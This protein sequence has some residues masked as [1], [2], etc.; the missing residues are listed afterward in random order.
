MLRPVDLAHGAPD[1]PDALRRAERL[2]EAAHD[3]GLDLTGLTEPGGRVAA[4]ACQLAP[5]LAAL[6]A[7]DPYLNRLV[8]RRLGHPDEEAFAF[9]LAAHTTAVSQLFA[10]LGE[11]AA[12]PADVIA[13]LSGEL[14]EDAE[15]EALARLGFVDLTMAGAEL[16]RARRHPGSPL[17][18][19]ASDRIARVGAALLTEIASS[20]DPDQALRFLGELCARRPGEW[21]IWRLLDE[22]PAICCL[23]GSVLG[24]SAYLARTLIDTPELIDLLVDVGIT[25]PTRT[26]AQLANDLTAR[27]ATVEPLD[28]EATWS[29]L[30]EVKN[31]HVLRVGLADV[32]GAL[33]PLAVCA[34]LTA[35]A[36]A[37]VAQALAIITAQLVVTHGPPPATAKLAVLGLGKLGGREL[38]YAADLDVVFVFT[39]L[40]DEAATWFSRCAQ[41][42]LGALRQRTPRGRL[43][44]LD[45]RLRPS[46]TAGVLVTSLAGWRRYHAEQAR[47]WERQVL[48]KLRPIAGDRELGD[49][50]ARLAAATVY[51]TPLAAPLAAAGEIRAMRERIERELGGPRDLK[52]GAGGIM[53]IEFAA[54]YLQL[55]HGPAHPALRTTSTQAALRA[56]AACGVAPV[57]EIELLDQGYAFLRT[58]EHRMRVVHDQPVHRLPD[59]RDELDKLA[60]RSGFLEGGLLLEHVTRWQIEIR[61][62]YLSLLGA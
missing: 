31:G 22:N 52:T 17:S 48:L 57:R 60:R 49:E 6:L 24:A 61:A 34:E 3:S 62:A 54:Q 11:P 30:A 9:E 32:A 43:Y 29:A 23:L 44:E 1:A 8:A 7:K 53:D 33:D 36:E 50:V 58:I 47:L 12:E 55:V 14:P 28:P 26:L 20:A 2:L 25:P 21:S 19:G 15:A 40:D 35:I 39:A 59:T 38:G 37:C 45:T 51:G 10:T 42:L 27:L 4:V 13:L 56:A 18:P 46:G 41:R 5:Y 16:A